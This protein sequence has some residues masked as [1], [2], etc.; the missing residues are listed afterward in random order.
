M[1]SPYST[2]SSQYRLYSTHVQDECVHIHAHMVIVGV[3]NSDRPPQV[4]SEA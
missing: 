3:R 1:C 4:G 2:D